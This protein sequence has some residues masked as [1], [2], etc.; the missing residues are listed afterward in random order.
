LHT[1]LDED[2]FTWTS[3]IS[4]PANPSAW[5]YPQ[6]RGLEISLADPLGVILR[7]A[8]GDLNLDGMID[9]ADVSALYRQ[10]GRAGVAD[11]NRDGHVDGVDLSLLFAN[12]P[13]ETSVNPIAAKASHPTDAVLVRWG[14]NA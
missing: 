10:W 13:Q 6:R 4:G 9:A 7:S 12:W 2:W 8:L 1:Q 14:H 11:L 3:A 5:S